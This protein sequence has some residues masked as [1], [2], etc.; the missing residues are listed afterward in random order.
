MENQTFQIFRLVHSSPNEVFNWLEENKPTK[1]KSIFD[2]DR[3]ELEKALIARNEP[4]INLGLALFGFKANTGIT[5]FQKEDTTIKKAVLAGTTIGSGLGDTWVESSGELNKL[6][7]RFDKELLVSFITNG[8]IEDSLLTNL[9]ERKSPFD[10]LDDEK[11]Y[12]LLWATIGNPRI[13]TP[14]DDRWLDGFDEYLYRR[15][16]ST[17]WKLFEVLP[18]DKESAAL[19][20]HL[21]EKLVPDQPHDMDVMA[22]IKRWHIEEKDEHI[23]YFELC[24]LSIARLVKEFKEQFKSFKDSDDIALR[25]SYYGRY[26]AYKPENVREL[27][28]K[29]ND[30]FLD[31]ALNNINLF[32]TEDIRDELRQCCWDYKDPLHDL[33]YPNIFNS[34]VEYYTKKHPEW[35]KDWDGEIP[36]DEVED[37]ISKA[38]IRLNVLNERIKGISKKLIESE[39][40][41]QQPLIDEVRDLLIQTNAYL[42]QL[43]GAKVP[44]W[45]WIIAGIIIGYVIAKLF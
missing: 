32:Q 43:S 28:E 8:N 29:D 41:D 4:L 16:F 44:V 15:V 33:L 5:L 21:G 6:L 25:L 39:N 19:L 3:E 31:E 30:K 24:R 23:D 20:A 34:R 13:S 14:Y 17:A 35:F 11:W 2:S 40:E 12:T 10:K 22:V 45:V 9:Y 36:L 18:V 38:N 1:K 27:F 7:D 42:S 26:R 37:P